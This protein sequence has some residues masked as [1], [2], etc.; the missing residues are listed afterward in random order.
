[1]KLYIKFLMVIFV[2]T[3][4]TCGFDD[5]DTNSSADKGLANNDGNKDT[6]SKKEAIFDR[7]KLI[8]NYADNIVIP[9][10]EAFQNE[11]L[12]FVSSSESYLKAINEVSAD[13]PAKKTELETAWKALMLKNIHYR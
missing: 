1:M 6:A 13:I 11:S 9:A 2:M 5:E 7:A 4:F 8:K 3:T 10:Y 12:A